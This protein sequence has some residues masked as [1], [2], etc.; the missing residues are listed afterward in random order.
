MFAGFLSRWPIE[1]V[2]LLLPLHQDFELELHV[3]AIICLRRGLKRTKILCWYY[4]VPYQR[5]EY[6]H[7]N[8]LMSEMHVEDE[9]TSVN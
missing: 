9:V 7:Y 8:R 4:L 5:L 1:N 6:R 2:K 3:M